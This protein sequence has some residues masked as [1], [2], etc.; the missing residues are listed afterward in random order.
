MRPKEIARAI[1]LNHRFLINRLKRHIQQLMYVY[2][3]SGKY[4]KLKIG[5]KRRVKAIEYI[6]S[7]NR[8]LKLV[9]IQEKFKINMN[10]VHG[11]YGNLINK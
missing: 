10:Y 6:V 11:N 9:E 1:R 8:T 4:A 7:T 2:N 3:T 5:I